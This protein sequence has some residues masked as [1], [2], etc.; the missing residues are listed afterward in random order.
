M[1]KYMADHIDISK[2]G[3]FKESCA[4]VRTRL[5]DMV[6]AVEKAM[7]NKAEEVFVRM[8]RD[9]NEIVAG[10]NTLQ[11]A[12]RQMR[13]QV[14][15]AIVGREEASSLVEVDD[16]ELK[17]AT[18]AVAEAKTPGVAPASPDEECDAARQL[19]VEA[20]KDDAGHTLPFLPSAD[21]DN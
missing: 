20:A 9:Y 7:A 1:K 8:S 6:S 13:A 18:G 21:V 12:E 3:M 15:A 5:N 16:A 10:K 14:A 4:E 11:I 2:S 17:T 19:K